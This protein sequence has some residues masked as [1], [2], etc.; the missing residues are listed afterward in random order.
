MQS[1]FPRTL[2]TKGH[3]VPSYM[4]N[5]GIIYNI[6][7]TYIALLSGLTHKTHSTWTNWLYLTFCGEMWGFKLKYVLEWD[8]LWMGLLKKYFLSETIIYENKPVYL[9]IS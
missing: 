3:H 7:T 6:Y 2:S 8:E 9:I 1:L 5:L 4:I